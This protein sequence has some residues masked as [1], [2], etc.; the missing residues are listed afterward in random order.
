MPFASAQQTQSSAIQ[1]ELSQLEAS[2]GGRLGISAIDTANNARVQYR[3]EERFPFASTGK[4]IVV[5]AIL[6]ESEKNPEILRKQITY[7]QEEV[8]KSG[9]APITQQHIG[10]GM[11]VSELCKA[12]IEYSDNAATNFL[13]K[14]LGGPE[15]V[16]TYARSID[17]TAFRLDWWEP[18]LTPLPGNEQD[19]TT[20]NAMV[21]SLKRLT[22]DD[23]LGLPQR[24]Q[25]QTWLRDNTT[26]NDKIRAGVPKGWVV[27]DKTGNGIYGTTNDIA[28]IWPPQCAPIVMV[29]YLTQKEKDAIERDDIIPSAVRMILN[30]FAQHDQCV[31]N[32]I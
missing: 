6:K 20:P 24:K 32:A 11:S 19:T 26:G 15:A 10:G 29:I 14:T 23:V 7:T 13:V 16:T 3:A 8:D 18:N 21:E 2:S 12:A 22:L 9:Y 1:N 31:K 5:S 17:D 28:V 4:V 25:L 30:E 27:G